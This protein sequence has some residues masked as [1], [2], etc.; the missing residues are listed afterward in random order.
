MC[1]RR[2]FEG[3]NVREGEER[4]R[5]RGE[6]GSREGWEFLRDFVASVGIF[7]LERGRVVSVFCW[8]QRE[9]EGEGMG[10]NGSGQF[11]VG[12]G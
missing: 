10:G 11:W 2:G 12:A 4:K 1:E 5:E 6:T 7:P 9:E 3:E 8:L